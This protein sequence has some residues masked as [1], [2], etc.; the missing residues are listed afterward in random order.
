MRVRVKKESLLIYWAVN[1]TLSTI[2]L[3]IQV[4]LSLLD[5]NT[6]TWATPIFSQLAAVQ[7]KIPGATTPFADEA[8]FLTAFKACFSN[9]D[10]ATT[11][12]VELTKLCADKSLHEKHTTAEFSALFK[13]PVDRSGYEDLELCNKYL[14][15]IPSRVY[16]KIELETFTT[17]ESADKCATEEAENVVVHVV[18]HPDCKALRPASMRPSEKETSPASASAVGKKGTVALGSTQ[19][20]TSAPVA[21]PS[22]STSAA[23]A[24]SEQSE[25]A[26]LM[27]QMKSMHEKLEHYW[28]MKEE[29]F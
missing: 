29:F 13:G 26:G 22:V 10:D 6:R 14:S 15:G 12:Q 17:W 3:K 19:A 5:G 18:V 4:A 24:K 27:A 21:S 1:T 16:Q 28:A 11:A 8:A 7:I 25:L 9:L 2:E 20:A 23:L